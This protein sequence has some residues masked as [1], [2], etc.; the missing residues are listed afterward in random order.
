MTKTPAQIRFDNLVS[1]TL[2]PE[3]KAKRYR[4]TG[5]NF[6]LYSPAGWEKIVNI[7]KS[8]FSNKNDICFTVNTGLYLP[9]ADTIFET[10]RGEKFLEPDCLVRK[11]IGNLNGLQS[12]LW[13]D[14]TENTTINDLE[15]R[16]KQNFS[17]FIIPYLESIQSRDDIL[18]QI[19]W[20]HR[21]NDEMAIRT[22]F[23]CGYQE[24]ARQW[25]ED[26]INT[27]IYRKWR[28]QLI[29]LKDL[30]V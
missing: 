1:I 22:L 24:E 25:I 11:R 4:K 26:E 6:R 29:K 21:P 28:E 27:T 2:W 18:K 3:F 17:Q 8:M 12:D 16:V 14:L 19:I 13:Y 23:I 30:L 5:N 15:I 7:Q 9:E 10:P 20:E